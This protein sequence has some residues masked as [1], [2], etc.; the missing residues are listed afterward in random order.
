MKILFMVLF[1]LYQTCAF[2]Q[3]IE[4]PKE[5]S[6]SE[7]DLKE[8]ID[9]NFLEDGIP[10]P[11]FFSELKSLNQEQRDIFLN[12]FCKWIKSYITSSEFQAKYNNHIEY[13]KPDEVAPIITVD[14]RIKQIEEQIK[15]IEKQSNNKS[16]GIYA[17]QALN[18][19]LLQNQSYLDYLKLNKEDYDNN[20]K[21]RFD[22]EISIFNEK[23]K[24]YEQ[25]KD[26]KS[27]LVSKLQ[28]FQVFFSGIDFSAELVYSNK[29]KNFKNPDYQTKS[30]IWKACFRAGKEMTSVLQK[31]IDDWIKELESK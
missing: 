23:Q 18:D 10:Y 3:T 19:S 9:N 31:F 14:S 20:E 4:Y 7:S 13:Y 6:I 22:Q 16:L 28:F 15:D 17:K 26:F 1:F 30:T 25:R 21:Q 27:F 5:L 8:W 29:I 2:A 24:V 12:N 11:Y